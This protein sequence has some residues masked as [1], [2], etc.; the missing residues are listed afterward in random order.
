VTGFDRN[1]LIRLDAASLDEL[2]AEFPS[3]WKAIGARLVDAV[4]A[5][6]AS[7]ETFV[8]ESQGAAKPWRQKIHKS[9][10]NPQVL[11]HALPRLAAARMARLAVE[12]TLLSAA[13]GTSS[14][15]IRLGLWSG[16]LI[17]RLFFSRGLTRKPVALRTF[18]LLWPLVRQRRLLLPLVQSKGIYCFYSRELI[19]A[20]GSVFADQT[21]LEIGAGDGTLSRF[22]AAEGVAIDATD[23]HSWAHAVSYP[24]DVEKLD[25]GSALRRHRPSAVLCS[26]PPPGNA[27]ERK[28]LATPEVQLYVVVTS[29]HRFAASDWGAYEAQSS[30]DWGI[31]ERLSPLVLPPELDP[32]V[33]VFRRRPARDA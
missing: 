31:D 1:A 11:A 28:V 5:G 22:L 24:P 33:L 23:D 9:R 32:A 17:Q 26:F 25:A 29:R 8:R 19:Q 14:G 18:R 12:R 20:L 10:G 15:S 13:A 2:M 3:E 7:I 4:K 30:F 27:F 6:P 21:V 16:V